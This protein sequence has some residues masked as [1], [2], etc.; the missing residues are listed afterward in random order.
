MM[1]MMMMMTVMALTSPL[2]VPSVP[3]GTEYGEYPEWGHR[4]DG[5]GADPPGGYRRDGGVAPPPH[6]PHP[7]LLLH[8]PGLWGNPIAIAAQ[9]TGIFSIATNGAHQMTRC[10]IQKAVH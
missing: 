6:P 8:N 3:A 2:R 10:C 1:M 9:V 5:H 4:D 7:H